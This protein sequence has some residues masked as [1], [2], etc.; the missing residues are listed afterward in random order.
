MKELFDDLRNCVPEFRDMGKRK[1]LRSS[2][3]EILSKSVDFIYG[4]I[5]EKEVVDEENHRLCVEL[6]IAH[7]KTTSN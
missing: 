4:L 7:N 2:N 5:L 3:W 1:A 6:S